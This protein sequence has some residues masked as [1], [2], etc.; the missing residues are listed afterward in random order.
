[1]STSPERVEMTIQVVADLTIVRFEDNK[2]LDEFAIANMGQ[3][4]LDLVEKQGCRKMILNFEN[5]GALSSAA[6]GKLIHLHKR[7][8][9]ELKGQLVMCGI[10][11][12]LLTA[13][14]LLQLERRFTIVADEDTALQ[15]F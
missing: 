2:I 5:V 3:R 4:L 7:I 13:F 14:R 12:Y 10:K 8:V 6:I 11:E 15:R 1:M 9:E